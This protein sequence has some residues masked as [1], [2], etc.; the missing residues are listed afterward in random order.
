M[1][2]PFFID[3][4]IADEFLRTGCCR[5]CKSKG[6]F[7]SNYRRK[8]R[9]IHK[10]LPEKIVNKYSFRFS[11]LCYKCRRR[12][13]PPS[14]MFLG[15][16]VYVAIGILWVTLKNE[17]G[18]LPRLEVLRT[19]LGQCLSDITI[20]RWLDWWQ[21]AVW[22]SPFWKELRGQLQGSI[23]RAKF[24]TGV[25]EHFKNQLSEAGSIF[26]SILNL[27]SPITRPESY[28]Y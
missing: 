22:E 23:F 16:K 6:L 18:T 15:R 8:P 26:E 2:V 25:W 11:F 9:G 21:S 14:V 7:R 24:L 17:Q 5:H 19:L 20:A 10:E 28:P 12:T 4:K 27:F 1:A 13:T 3:Q